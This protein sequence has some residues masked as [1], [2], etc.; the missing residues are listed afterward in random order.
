MSPV[1]SQIRKRFSS[2]EKS[3]GR[4]LD[5]PLWTVL[6]TLFPA[7]GA[8]GR[9]LTA[10][11]LGGIINEDSSL[12]GE[13]VRI[14]LARVTERARERHLSLERPLS[15]GGVMFLGTLKVLD[16][17][18]EAVT[19][20]ID[21]VLAMESSREGAMFESSL[22]LSFL[23]GEEEATGGDGTEREV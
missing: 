15:L 12:S 17:V 18:S 6:G 10:L 19:V 21:T 16:A 22:L 11:W 8:K 7:V 4:V 1:R 2:S 13:G 20:F 9:T 14:R 23:V 3:A 5:F